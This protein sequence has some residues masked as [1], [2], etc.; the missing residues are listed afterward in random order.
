MKQT[1][2]SHPQRTDQA[3]SVSPGEVVNSSLGNSDLQRGLP[4]PEGTPPSILLDEGRAEPPIDGGVERMGV[5]PGYNPTG[6]VA[7]RGAKGSLKSDVD[8]ADAE[9]SQKIS[10]RDQAG[11]G[12]EGSMKLTRDGPTIGHKLVSQ[13]GNAVGGTIGASDKGYS[14]SGTWN[15]IGVE[16]KSKD[17]VPTYGGSVS[18][19]EDSKASFKV[20]YDRGATVFSD[21]D[22]WKIEGAMQTKQAGGKL[23]LSQG[24]GESA[25][26]VEGKFG[27]LKASA[28]YTSLSRSRSGGGQSELLGPSHVVEHTRGEGA[29][30]GVQV[31][32]GV[33]GATMSTE[34]VK[35]HQKLDHDGRYDVAAAQR[36]REVHGQVAGGMPLRI[37]DLGIEQGMEIVTSSEAKHGFAIDPV[38]VHAGWAALDAS[39]TQRAVARKEEGVHIKDTHEVKRETAE[40]RGLGLGFLHDETSKRVGV[41]K[42]VIEYLLDPT[43]PSAASYAQDYAQL[44]LLP[45]W[46]VV[47]PEKL[48]M[49]MTQALN[50]IRATTADGQPPPMWA[51][52]W[53]AFVRENHALVQA[54]NAFVRSDV[55]SDGPTNSSGV[56]M[57]A[58]TR[59]DSKT[60]SESSKTAMLFNSSS[61]VVKDV[62]RRRYQGVDGSMVNEHSHS[63]AVNGG[64]RKVTTSGGTAATTALRIEQNGKTKLLPGTVDLSPKVVEA[65]GEYINEDEIH[66]GRAW[67]HMAKRASDYWRMFGWSTDRER[68]VQ[69]PLDDQ[70]LW[71]RVP[72]DKQFGLAETFAKVTGPKEFKALAPDLQLIFIESTAYVNSGPQRQDRGAKPGPGNHFDALAAVT[73]IEDPDQRDAAML[74]FGR[75]AARQDRDPSSELGRLGGLVGGGVAYLIDEARQ[76]RHAAPELASGDPKAWS[77]ELGRLFGQGTTANAALLH[78]TERMREQGGAPFLSEVFK[79]APYKALDV[80]KRLAANSFD[81][82]RDFIKYVMVGTSSQKELDAWWLKVEDNLR[83]QEGDRIAERMLA[84]PHNQVVIDGDRGLGGLGMDRK[85]EVAR[86]EHLDQRGVIDRFLRERKSGASAPEVERKIHRARLGETMRKNDAAVFAGEL[87]AFRAQHGAEEL[88]LL[89][90][91]FSVSDFLGVLQ[92]DADG[93]VQQMLKGTSIGQQ[94]GIR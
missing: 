21:D 1:R 70:G 14:G 44:G 3:Q 81:A 83:I 36:L 27:P 87:R 29:R 59:T 4:A 61:S 28:G 91:A 5:Q 50:E 20:S 57:L 58:A 13:D 79:V 71:A 17:G 22:V 38:L 80:A 78:L 24:N 55:L 18:H 63:L 40:N 8:Y 74:L 90:Q 33:S 12:R 53:Q 10:T 26:D 19:G 82:P 86:L 60:Y 89:L 51:E 39:T 30:G 92:A 52:K 31:I 32:A 11:H 6:W 34:S 48:V 88:D 46:N 42:Q 56:H 49:K 7:D 94:L 35:A 66:S 67:Q 54:I 43:D 9:W 75:Q 68:Q 73:L 72:R 2:R 23:A 25:A 16:Y 15:G 93:S 77:T 64:S 47:A 37:E 62:E 84:K 65:I 69:P 45:N 76:G 41:D 85:L